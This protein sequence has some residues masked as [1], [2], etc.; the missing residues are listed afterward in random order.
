LLCIDSGIQRL[1]PPPKSPKPRLTDARDWSREMD[2]CMTLREAFF[3]N[4]FGLVRIKRKMATKYLYAVFG[5]FFTSPLR[6]KK[7]QVLP[8]KKCQPQP[9]ILCKERYDIEYYLNYL[10]IN[11]PGQM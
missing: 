5:M 2:Y 8:F 11:D 1:S 10:Q 7:S 4:E 6:F 9:P 3:I